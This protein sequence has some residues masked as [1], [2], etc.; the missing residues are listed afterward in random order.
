MKLLDADFYLY[1][2]QFTYFDSLTEEC[3][4]ARAE[5]VSDEEIFSA[6]VVGM[7]DSETYAYRKYFKAQSKNLAQS[8]KNVILASLLKKYVGRENCTEADIRREMDIGHFELHH[9]STT[10][11]IT[12]ED[13]KRKPKTITSTDSRRIGN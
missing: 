11:D 4:W 9:V 2:P 13:D 5:S 7:E 1:P 3:R 6:I 12:I 8:N 10:Y